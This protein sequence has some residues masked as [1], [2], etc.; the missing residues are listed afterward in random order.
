[1]AKNKKRSKKRLYCKE[2]NLLQLPLF[3]FEKTSKKEIEISWED[4]GYECKVTCSTN[5]ELPGALEM[6][7]FSACMR[8]WVKQGMSDDGVL[9]E[10]TDIADELDLNYRNWCT[11]IKNSILKLG[12]ARYEFYR[13]F[14]DVKKRKMTSI[15][16]FCLFTTVQ[17]DE[18]EIEDK[19]KINKYKLIFAPQI[20]CNLEKRYYQWLDFDL[21]KRIETGVGRKLYEFLEKKRYQNKN[22]KFSISEDKIYRWIPITNVDIYQRRKT[23]KKGI[24]SLVK[25]DY[26]KGAY[27]ER[28]LWVYEY[29]KKIPKS[30]D[31][32]YQVEE[33]GQKDK[34]LDVLFSEAKHL[35]DSMKKCISKHYSEKGFDY[36]L[37]NIRYANIRANKSYLT[38]LRRSLKED[39]A[40]DW[41]E[42]QI[43]EALDKKL[44]DNQEAEKY[45]REMKEKESLDNQRNLFE[46][47]F[48]KLSYDK[49]RALWVKADGKIDK[50]QI[51]RGL[52]VNIEFRKLVE[53]ELTKDGIEFDSEAISSMEFTKKIFFN[54]K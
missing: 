16:Q 43:K 2:K 19:R 42:T 11:K 39:W 18:F 52:L 12:A 29:A 48:N 46:S 4:E 50:K 45:Q 17:A 10:N 49:K 54:P 24:A 30:K 44:I 14:V 22:Q 41:K 51:G 20:K 21:Y 34:Q 5:R 13:C 32:S 31:Q 33:V 40:V 8:I 27:L 26:L 37:W 9:I 23:M 15:R 28:G 38:Y 25:H 36:V 47:E 7:I 6:D 1:M 35:S 3:Y 53:T